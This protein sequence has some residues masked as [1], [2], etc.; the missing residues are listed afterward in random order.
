MYSSTR[1]KKLRRVL[2]RKKRRTMR[3]I[4]MMIPLK[5]AS[6]PLN[7]KSLHLLSLNLRQNLFLLQ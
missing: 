6:N 7:K 2:K 4:F 1:R 3:M 5:R